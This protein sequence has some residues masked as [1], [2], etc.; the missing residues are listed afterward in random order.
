MTFEV[1]VQGQRQLVAESVNNMDEMPRNS[2][3]PPVR[4]YS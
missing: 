3:L 1:C 4:Q 2:K